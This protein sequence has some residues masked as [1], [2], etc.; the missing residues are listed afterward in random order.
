MKSG[1]LVATACGF[2]GGEV[3][4]LG[5]LINEL[6]LHG[7][8]PWLWLYSL[9]DLT[10]WF[11]GLHSFGQH[12]WLAHCLCCPGAACRPA[13]WLP[14]VAEMDARGGGWRE[15]LVAAC[16]Q[17]VDVNFPTK[18][19]IYCYALA[20]GPLC[21]LLLLLLLLL[22]T[23]QELKHSQKSSMENINNPPRE[24]TAATCPIPPSRPVHNMPSLNLLPVAPYL[25][26]LQS[27]THLA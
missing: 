17:H 3:G 19:W 13:A 25:C 11:C 24:S 20:L 18:T 10:R 21:Q 4:V 26:A 1:I 5:D 27:K 12:G 6:Q 9:H 2:R 16:V 23:F 22:L 15:V 14:R 7:G 8:S